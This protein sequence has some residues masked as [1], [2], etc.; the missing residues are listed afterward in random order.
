MKSNVTI[1]TEF[2]PGDYGWIMYEGKVIKAKV[3]SIDVCEDGW[4][5]QMEISENGITCLKG[6]FSR[7]QNA[8]KGVYSTQEEL[9]KVWNESYIEGEAKVIFGGK[10]KVDIADH[11]PTGKICVLFSELKEQHDP[12][13]DISEEET[14]EIENRGQ[15]VLAFNNIRSVEVVEKA[16]TMVKG[17]LRKREE[18]K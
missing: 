16:L 3:H 10:I 17:E 6:Y 9:L 12:G 15:V 5:Y 4:L 18:K 1:L 2:Q 14:K 11:L 7:L 13:V 8:M